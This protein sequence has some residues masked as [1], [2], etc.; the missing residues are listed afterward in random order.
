MLQLILSSLAIVLAIGYCLFLLVRIRRRLSVFALVGGLLACVV[1]EFCDFQALI[2]PDELAIWKQAALAAEGVLPFFWLLFA[3]TFSREGG[4]RGISL[5]A[6]ILL[7]A[8]LAFPFAVFRLSLP[9]VFYSP[10]FVDEKLLFLGAGGYFFYVALM[11]FLVVAMFH[12]E[13]TLVAL[14]RPDRWRVKFEVIGAGVLLAVLVVYYSQALLY[15][16]IDMNLMPVRSLSLVLAIV[17]MVV[18]RCRRGE[19]VRIQVSRDIAYRSVVV[20][21]VGFY[22]IGLGLFGAGMRYLGQSGNRVFFI[23]L[24]VVCGLAV[25]AALLSEKIRRRIRVVLHKNFYQRK[26]D[27]RQEWQAFTDKLT[28]AKNREELERGI[29]EF[30]SETYSLSGTALYLRDQEAAR[31]RCAA[32]FEM[33]ENVEPVLVAHPL[34]ERMRQSDWVINLEKEDPSTSALFPLSGAFFL[35]PLRFDQSLEGFVV[36][37]RRIYAAEILTYEDFDL[38]KIL[39]HQAISVLLSRKLYAQ[40]VAANEM[41]TIG[42]VSTFVIHDLKNLVSGLA[43]MVDNARDYIDDPEFRDDMFETLENTV[44]NMKGLIARL[45]NVKQKPQLELGHHDLL[46]LAK[47]GVALSGGNGV[48]VEGDSVPVQ[49]DGVEVQ[50]VL[51]N[52]INNAREATLGDAAILV[53]VGQG[54]MAYVRVSDQGCGMSDDFIRQRLFRPFETTKKKGLG[55]G[56]YQCRQVIEDHGGRIGVKSAEGEGSTFTLW[57]PLAD[58]AL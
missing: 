43:L 12:L 53:E 29:L 46:A 49:V 58:D 2:R 19:V 40:L 32:V 14:P 33:D 36:L 35:V 18:S 31:F 38:M 15:R 27:Y 6:M 52:L 44:D 24:A 39:A 13:R 34:I 28:A 4:W 56:L 51:L 25:V 17:L 8:T 37:G 50:K 54:D 21:S 22:L 30:F 3:L 5:P 11:T 41:A 26:Y 47:A 20:L 45:Q 48:T 1:L 57:L 16:S 55:I 10:D 7:A 9:E 23:M 42:R